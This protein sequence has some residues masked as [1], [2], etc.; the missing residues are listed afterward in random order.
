MER[1]VSLVQILQ[2]GDALTRD[3]LPSRGVCNRQVDVE[4]EQ[5]RQGQ[6]CNYYHDHV[7]QVED[8]LR[9]PFT[10]GRVRQEGI[11]DKEN[12]T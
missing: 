12:P 9:E 6:A 2:V 5:T 3:A 11:P 1:V 4:T 7:E 10:P 8:I